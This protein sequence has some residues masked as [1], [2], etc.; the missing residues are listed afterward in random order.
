MAINSH[1]DDNASDI[2]SSLFPPL[3]SSG[4]TEAPTSASVET[5][6]PDEER[7]PLWS[8]L[9]FLSYLSLLILPPRPTDE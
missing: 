9:F 4:R 3:L 2:S 6:L 1:G 8:R 7:C 5:T